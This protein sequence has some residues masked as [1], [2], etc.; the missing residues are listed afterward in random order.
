MVPFGR[1]QKHPVWACDLKKIPI[2]QETIEI[3][4]LF[5]L[6]PYQLISSGSM[7]IGTDHGSQL[8]DALAKEGIHAAVIGKAVEGNDRVI[9]NDGEKRFLEPP[10]ADELYRAFD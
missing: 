10:K 7:L 4:E 2:R 3:C 5:N 8:V 1:W 9:F 6:N